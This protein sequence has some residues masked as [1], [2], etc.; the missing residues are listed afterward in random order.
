VVVQKLFNEDILPELSNSLLLAMALKCVAFRQLAC[1][2]D[3]LTDFSDTSDM[4]LML[5]SF[6]NEHFAESNA[7]N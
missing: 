1:Q 2:L 3:K 5:G 7:Y 6:F 4:V